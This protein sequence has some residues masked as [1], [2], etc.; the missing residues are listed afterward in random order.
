MGQAVLVALA[1]DARFQVVGGV[2]QQP[3]HDSEFASLEA[4]PERPQVVIDF[5][6]PEAL[7]GV[8]DYCREH[9]VALVSGTTGV[10]TQQLDAMRELGTIVPVLYAANMSRGVAVLKRLVAQAAQALGETADIEVLEHHHRNKLDAPSGTAL[11]LGDIA[12]KAAGQRNDSSPDRS[13]QRQTGTVGH[14]VLRGGDVVGEHTVYFHLA[15][16]RLELIHRAADR[17]LFAI[18]AVSAAA[19]LVKQETA[20]FFGIEDT[21]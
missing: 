10:S 5:S 6:L 12:A 18:G 8:I 13:G 2:R 17:R 15:G 9:Q 11:M 21:L 19:W 20:G 1:E 3:C 4:L 14:A 7:Q 16:E